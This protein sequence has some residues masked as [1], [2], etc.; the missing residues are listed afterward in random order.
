MGLKL[1]TWQTQMKGSPG[2]TWAMNVGDPRRIKHSIH[3]GTQMHQVL[4]CFA[5]VPDR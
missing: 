1:V 4:T 3:N 2:R 5:M